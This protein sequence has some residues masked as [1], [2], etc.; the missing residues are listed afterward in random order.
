MSTLTKRIQVLLSSDQHKRLDTLA[1]SR[2]TSIGAL[3]REAV[4]KFYI[5]SGQ[6]ERL[7]AVRTLSNFELPV[8]NCEQMER[9]SMRV[10][11]L[12]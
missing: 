5:Q 4:E 12:D 7:K 11:D 10:G 1:K 2:G 6:E 3:I 9:E 8:S